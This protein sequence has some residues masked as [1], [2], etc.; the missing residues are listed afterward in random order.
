MTFSSGLFDDDI[1]APVPNGAYYTTAGWYKNTGTSTGG[2]ID[3]GLEHIYFIG[4]CPNVSAVQPTLAV[5][6]GISSP[7]DGANVTITTGA[8]DDGRWIAFGK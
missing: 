3:T 5:T 6:P 7:V 1:G 2:A 8:G 4:F